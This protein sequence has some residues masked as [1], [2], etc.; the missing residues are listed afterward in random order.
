MT[1]TYLNGDYLPIEEARVS[2]LDRGFLF[3][4]GVYEVIPA[5]GGRLFRLAQH[6][7][8][9]QNSLDAVQIPNPLA[10]VE[11]ERMLN[12]LLARNAEKA[13]ATGDQSVYL[14]V[15]RGVAAKR[16]HQFPEKTVPTVYAVS[17]PLPVPDPG[18]AEHGAAAV[19]LP[20][21]RWLRC[22][23]KAITLLPNVLF[24]QQA[25]EAGAMEAI[26]V[27]D[28]R[29]I[30]GSAS[31]VFLVRGGKLYTPPIGPHLL[32]GITRDL[33][34]E[35]AATHGVPCEERDVPE[36]WLRDADEIW[37]T[38]SIREILPITRLDDKP[39]GNG[40]PGPVWKVMKAVFQDYK[41]AVRRGEAA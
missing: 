40:R 29:V 1:I 27:R 28:A 32:P 11:W 24:R 23:I 3:G 14:Q 13:H 19:T 2:V 36:A 17:N 26:L 6:L 34:L 39:V 7:Q 12:T 5:Y 41:N 10:A 9:L 37:V 25:V 16:D 38:S 21:N 4:D 8:R 33:I 20:D 30:E 35:L 31:N 22:N 18:L 15:T